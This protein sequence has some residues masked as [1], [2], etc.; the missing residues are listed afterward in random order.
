M[1]KLNVFLNKKISL[2]GGFFI[3]L[4]AITISSFLIWQCSKMWEYEFLPIEF[5][6]MPKENLIIS[7]DKTE[8][9]QGETVEI[10]LENNGGKEECIGSIWEIER[11]EEEKWIK[12]KRLWC[13]CGAICNIQYCDKLPPGEKIEHQW[14]QKE[15]WCDGSLTVSQQVLAGTYRIRVQVSTKTI[16]SKEFAIREKK[17][18]QGVS[19][20][21]DK[22]EYGQEEIVKIIFKNG[23][24]RSIWYNKR[25]SCS[26]PFWWVERLK[27]REWERV[28]VLSTWCLWYAPQ[29]EAT[30][31]G[32]GQEISAKWDLK[33]YDFQLDK[34]KFAQAGIYRI[35]AG[36]GFEKEGIGNF[37]QV[38]NGKTIYS[39]EFI[40]K[41]KTKNEKS[42]NRDDD[43]MLVDINCCGCAAGGSKT[44]I[45]KSFQQEWYQKLSCSSD[46][47]MHC[48]EEYNCD[49]IFTECRCIDNNCQGFR[50]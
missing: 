11:F 8:Y 45:N 46:T 1:L 29:H 50:K 17:E 14:S 4:S 32:V 7:T 20:S 21:T 48:P 34:R 35:G 33:V 44:C 28:S 22:T 30:E 2:P 37:A 27:G 49:F 36:Y 13:P 38:K 41:E 5:S 42:C 40:I 26:E 23:L 19:I 12:I 24:N 10:V 39:D 47:N 25:L 18:K 16:Y 15:N 43:C 3:I 9:E 31:L 6:E